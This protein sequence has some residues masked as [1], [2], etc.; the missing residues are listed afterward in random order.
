MQLRLPGRRAGHAPA[1]RFTSGQVSTPLLE[2]I[3]DAEL[4][5]LNELL[6]WRCFTV[7]TAGRA[8][9][10]AAWSGKR[11][12][13]QA[14]PDPR[15]VELDTRIGLADKHVLEVGCFEGVHT[16]ALCQRAARVT[17]I[18]ARVENVVKTVVRCA[19]FDQRPRVMTIDLEREP[20]APG[21]L[22]ADVCHH[23]GVL[24]HL[25]DPVTHL[26]R[27]GEWIGEGLMLDTH[28]ALSGEATETFEVDGESFRYK[29]FRESGREDAFSGLRDHAKWLELDTIEG[30]LRE[31]GFGDV[32]VAERRDERNGPRVLIFAKRS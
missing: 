11:T 19:F 22:E 18:D 15:I 3:D 2:L 28:Y 27:I 12:E 16:V 24:Y 29:R 23:V 31:T 26:R 4:E 8:F 30:L 7:D 1:E 20:P 13:P 21:L 9:G 14:V 25:S 5:R 32:E 6:P 10:R 17:A